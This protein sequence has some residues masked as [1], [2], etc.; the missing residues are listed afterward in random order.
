MTTNYYAPQVRLDGHLLNTTATIA[1]V[2]VLGGLEIEWGAQNWLEDIT[3]STLTIQMLDPAG[4]LLPLVGSAGGN[5]IEVR[6]E[7]DGIVFTGELQDAEAELVKLAQPHDHRQAMY[8]WLVTMTATDPLGLAASDRKHGPAPLP[9]APGPKTSTHWGPTSAQQRWLD[10]QARMPG[11]VPL[12]R[13]GPS[14]FPVSDVWIPGT[15]PL[16]PMAGYEKQQNVSVLSVLHRTMRA[17][18]ILSRPYY[19]HSVG[20][21]HQ[22]EAGPAAPANPN[23]P[24]PLKIMLTDDDGVLDVGASGTPGLE[25][26]SGRDIAPADTIRVIADPAHRI[27]HIERVGRVEKEEDDPQGGKRLVY[28]EYSQTISTGVKDREVC[29]A[30]FEN[31]LS[32]AWWDRDASTWH[33]REFF[34][35][36]FTRTGP[37]DLSY[38]LPIT[39]APTNP[40]LELLRP[41]PPTY[42]RTNYITINPLEE[43]VHKSYYL[44]HSLTNLLPNCR[45][46][47]VIGG[48]LGY[49][50]D[51]GWEH[52][53]HTAPTQ[54]APEIAAGTVTLGS[55]TSTAKIGD[56]AD[57]LRIAD[58]ERITAPN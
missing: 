29:T 14:L 55:I 11:D 48:R 15:K 8:V 56:A 39:D 3:P 18:H 23:F 54:E 12:L 51:R 19:M 28:E 46:F 34:Q 38:R 40:N 25:V 21:V 7:P 13:R 2:T 49:T 32:A 45:A 1:G 57:M 53:L 47:S 42:Y 36:I 52:E 37:G 30:S 35:G 27:T 17:E 6:R 24:T 58:L 10:L 50:T 43:R 26:L 44:T 31:D 22:V 20:E 33:H 4:E 16:A 41:E 9:T 5:P